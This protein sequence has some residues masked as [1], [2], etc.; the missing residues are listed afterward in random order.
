MVA[1]LILLCSLK[2]VSLVWNIETF[3]RERELSLFF[4][5]FFSWRT[6]EYYG[7]ITLYTL[8]VIHGPRHQRW[9]SLENE[10]MW[11]TALVG[12]HC[13]ATRIYYTK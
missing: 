2:H 7:G 4:L 9:P 8:M 12:V 11:R 6:S 13:K 1:I 3:A 5:F 10:V